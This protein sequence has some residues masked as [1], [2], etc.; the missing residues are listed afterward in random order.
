MSEYEK[1]NKAMTQTA[2]V[3]TFR[4]IYTCRRVSCKHVWALDYRIDGRDFRG[5]AWGTREVKEGERVAF[6]QVSA[7]ERI[8]SQDDVMGCLCCP[9]CGCNLPKSNRVEGHY[10]ESIKCGSRCLNAKNGDCECSCGGA[11]HGANHL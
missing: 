10:R 4:T 9:A 11:N 2:E 6:K 8:T 5:V 7:G 3:T 1:E